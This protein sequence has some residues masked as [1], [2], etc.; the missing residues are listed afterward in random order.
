MAVIVWLKRV[1]RGLF[2]LLM[3]ASALGKLADMNGFAGIVASYRALPDGLLVPAAWGLALF[4]LGWQSGSWWARNYAAQ[5]WRYRCYISSISRGYWWR[6]RVDS[7][8]PTAVAS[9]CIGRVH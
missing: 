3:A 4:E 8:L 5:H 7:S 1:L 9:A 2:A 6:W